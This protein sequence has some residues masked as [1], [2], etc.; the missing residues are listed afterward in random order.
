MLL[1]AVIL[2]KLGI[3]KDDISSYEWVLFFSNA[4]SF[5]WSMGLRNGMLNYYPSINQGDRQSFLKSLM[6]GFLLVSSAVAVAVLLLSL[7]FEMPYESYLPYVLMYMFFSVNGSLLEQIYLLEERSEE[8]F[9]YATFSYG[10]FLILVGLGAKWQ[11]VMGAIYALVFWAGLRFL[12][13]ASE[14]LKRRG[15]ISMHT[16]YA[17]VS[18]STPLILYVLMGN[19]MEYVDGFLVEHFFQK[20]SFAVYRFGSRELPFNTIL[21]SGLVT[22]AIPIATASLSNSQKLIKKR[23][24]RLMH[25]LFPVSIVLM[26]I[27]P[28]LFQWFYSVDYAYSAE[29]FNIYLLIIISRVLV[30]QVFLY[31]YHENRV[32][33]YIALV[34]LIVNISLSIW[35][36]HI[37]GLKGIAF[38]TLIAY[39]VE[40]VI[41]MI[42]STVKLKIP[43]VSYL[44]LKPYAIY[45]IL[46]VCAYYVRTF[47]L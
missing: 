17:F 38:A 13:Y 2:V 39:I 24:G 29:I 16:F 41:L 7:V 33:L 8:Q 34:E 30:P 22:A 44:P 45:S 20:E 31:A 12:F 35:F 40:K 28:Y 4:I 11:G 1:S 42:Y 3:S 9:Y 5:F 23:I 25:F 32:L 10:L 27:S 43:V 46:L 19:G 21:V 26:F 18:F 6:S 15:N 14:Y 37:F 47:V 36:L